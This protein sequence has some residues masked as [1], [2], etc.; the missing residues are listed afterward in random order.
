MAP[1]SN[2]P[3]ARRVAE[4]CFDA[5]QLR[6]DPH[7][8]PALRHDLE[9]LAEH[10]AGLN[11]LKAQF[12]GN[13]VP[14]NE[15]TRP[16]NP[17]HAAIADFLI[18][19]AAAAGLSS[20]YDILIERRAW[21]YGA[22]FHGSLDGDEATARGHLQGPLLK[23]HG[24]SHRDRP[25][26]VW[27]PSQLH[28]PAVADRISKSKDWMAANLRQ[29]DLLVVGFW[30]DWDY[31]NQI[32]GDA[33]QGLDPL[34]VTV[35]DLS[36]VA[37]LEQKAPALWALAHQPHVNFTHVQES[38]ADAL[39]EL[40]SAFSEN[41]LR[42]VLAAGR[43]AFEVATGEVCD[44]AWLN[45]AGLDNE[46]LYDWRRDAEGVPVGRP[47]VTNRPRNG[48]TLGCFHLLLRRAGAV[49]GSRGYTLGGRRIRVVNGAESMLSSVAARLVEAPAVSSADVFVAVGAT[50]LG[51]PAHVV[52]AGTPGSVVRPAAGGT[53][54]TF[55]QARVELGV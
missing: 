41:Y 27:A 2:L 52:R 51:L 45:V 33:I 5:Y 29:K 20:N 22:D 36:G 26:T 4:M 17:G 23:F 34:S 8:N 32:I 35:I 39:E 42:Q 10:F 43:A 54:L 28:D 19:K 50:D 9:A 6:V 30:S 12:I 24:C 46:S 37:D 13:L 3:S 44:P 40:R 15:F 18:T 16:P 1:P 49:Q 21:D 31:L 25:S 11:T 53:W 55:E 7:I 47:A 14:W 38:G 48:E